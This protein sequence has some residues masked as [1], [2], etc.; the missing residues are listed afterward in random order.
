[1]HPHSNPHAIALASRC[2]S[3]R[4]AIDHRCAERFNLR[5][6]RALFEAASCL[7]M[8]KI[9]SAFFGPTHMIMKGTQLKQRM[10][11]ADIIIQTMVECSFR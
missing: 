7:V 1:M 11:S 4:L 8:S 5:D 10:P 6:G 2:I 9:V 3:R